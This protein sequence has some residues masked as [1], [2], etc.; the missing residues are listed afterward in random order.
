MYLPDGEL[1]YAEDSN[2]SNGFTE[3]QFFKY[4]DA[5]INRYISRRDHD[6]V[7]FPK[8]KKTIMF[9]DYQV[10]FFY[11][12]DYITDVIDVTFTIKDGT[13]GIFIK[14]PKYSSFSKVSIRYSDVV[15]PIKF[16]EKHIQKVKNNKPFLT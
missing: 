10:E 11:R 5:L 6:F 7:L 13:K 14:K 2:L 9:H 15:D 4:A 12:G 1:V 16:I 8:D 3:I